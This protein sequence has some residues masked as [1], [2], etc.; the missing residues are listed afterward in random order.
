MSNGNRVSART[1]QA[2]GNYTIGAARGVSLNATGNNIAN[3]A[4]LGG[5]LTGSGNTVT[6]GVAAVRRVTIINYSGGNIALAN[7][8]VGQTSDG[9]N[10][11]ANAQTLS[12]ITANNMFQDLTISATGNNTLLNGNV[13]NVL[14]VN[15]VANAQANV[16]VDIFVQGSVYKD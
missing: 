16:L 9:G 14:Y 1:P 3:I 15:L 6:S 4:I 7:V 10:L 2:F 5:G 13:S 11:V 12:S 8:S